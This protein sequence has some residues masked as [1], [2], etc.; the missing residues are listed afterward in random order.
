MADRKQKRL[1]KKLSQKYK[2]A[3]AT[4]KWEDGHGYVVMRLNDEQLLNWHTLPRKEGIESVNVAG[5]S[6]HMKELQE[7]CF[8][9]G[10]EV[11][12]IY[13]PDNPYGENAIAV[14]D[15]NERY[16]VGY[17]PKEESARILN[18]LQ[19]GEIEKSLVMWEIHKRKKR[20]SIRLLLVSPGASLYILS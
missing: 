15:A 8:T 7:D 18:K 1:R 10:S 12:L 2:Y 9:A 6:H 3:L 14:W 5:E 20:V 16:H 4:S 19:R 17:I 11:K 13:E